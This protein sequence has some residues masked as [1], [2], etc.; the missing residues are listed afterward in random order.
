MAP[1]G[2]GVWR[3]CVRLWGRR[4]E[5]SLSRGISASQPCASPQRADPYIALC[6]RT[7]VSLPGALSRC[8]CSPHPMR[9]LCAAAPQSPLCWRCQSVVARAELFCPSCS[10]LQPLD[11][12]QDFF[13]MLGCDHSFDIDIQELQKTYRNLQRLLHPDYF[14]QKSQHEQEISERHSSLVNKAYNTLLSPLSRGV[15]LLSLHGITFTEGT[16]DGVDAPFLFE[17]LE[18]NE[19]LNEMNNDAEI[20]DIGIFIQGDFEGA[21]MFLAKL[22][23]YSNILDQVKKKIIP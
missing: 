1:A 4:T 7:P 14:G 9:S 20:E 19:D 8:P 15:Y 16:E 10:A 13:H 2:Q 11:D 12:T 23:Y 17:I 18:I 6:R 5:V 22:K 3:C 21:K